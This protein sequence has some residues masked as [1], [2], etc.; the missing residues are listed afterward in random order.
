MFFSVNFLTACFSTQLYAAS[1]LYR[2]DLFLSYVCLKADIQLRERLSRPDGD[3]SGTTAARVVRGLLAQVVEAP[4]SSPSDY[5]IASQMVRRCSVIA[6]GDSR[7]GSGAGAM[8]A[9]RMGP[10]EGLMSL[11]SGL[12]LGALLLWLNRLYPALPLPLPQ[13]VPRNRIVGVSSSEALSNSSTAWNGSG[14]A[15]DGAAASAQPSASSSSKYGTLR[16]PTPESALGPV[17]ERCLALLL[18]LLHGRRYGI[19]CFLSQCT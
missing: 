18:V 10:V 13:T 16:A 6:P 8:V 17:G 9:R 1:E 2:D 14:A 7:A 4:R 11:W 3:V 15:E 5:T 19:S 12:G